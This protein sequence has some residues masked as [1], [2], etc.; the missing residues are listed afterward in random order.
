MAHEFVGLICDGNRRDEVERVNEQEGRA[1][2]IA[3][4]L[5]EQLYEAYRLG[6]DAVK[7]V[8]ERAREEALGVIAVW[9]MSDKNMEQRPPHQKHILYRIFEEFLVDLRDN[10]MDRRE[11]SEV[12]LVHMGKM[13]H[14]QEEAPRVKNLLTDIAWH[15][16]QRTDMVVAVCL[17]Y[18]GKDEQK[19][20]TAI[21]EATGHKGAVENRLDL[22]LLGIPYRPL[23][24][25]IRT[26]ETTRLKH[27]NAFLHPYEDD[28][29]REAYHA[30]YLPGYT[31]DM[32]SADLQEYRTMPRRKGQ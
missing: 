17:D 11:N 23:D 30:T 29:T 1:L 5:P 19:R 24:L 10:W 31:A 8:I 7:K 9:G 28:E 20:A 25:R 2:T 13:N 15:T 12:R 14:L 32:F 22:P 21:W 3:D 16:R 4:L 18:G 27:P 6:A 26:G